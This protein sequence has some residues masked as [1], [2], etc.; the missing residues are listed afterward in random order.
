[1]RRAPLARALALALALALAGGVALAGCTGRPGVEPSAGPLGG[2]ALTV[3]DPGALRTI[4]V[5]VLMPPLEGEGSEYRDMAEGAAVAA[6]RFDQ[7]GVSVRLVAALDNGTPEGAATGLNSLLHNPEVAG[8]VVASSGPHLAPALAAVPASGTAVVMPYDRGGETIEGVWRTGPSEGAV[9]ARLADAL[10]RKGVAHPVVVTPA[11][12]PLDTLPAALPLTWSSAPAGAD[13]ALASCANPATPIDCLADR[14]SQALA[15]G[16]ADSVVAVGAAGDQAQLVTALRSAL[17]QAQVPVFL[18]PEA[19]TPTFGRGL[20]T[21]GA[22]NGDYITVGPNTDDPASQA[23]ADGQS[24]RLFF[25]ALRLAAGSPKAFNVFG[26]QPFASAAQTADIASHDAVVALVRAAEQAGTT[27]A[28]AVREV[29]GGLGLDSHRG[30]AGP[31]LDFRQPNALAA[32]SVVVLQATT[33]NPGQRPPAGAGQARP[34]F[35]FAV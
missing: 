3:Y 8:V 35:W 2:V 7:G 21:S 14:A 15:A 4:S 20:T 11:G 32:A 16:R 31:A 13:P 10:A 1:M 30:L 26:D 25:E 9:E 33:A 29:L 12:Q 28:A 17:G 27:D 24:A 22:V 5:G 6:F 23:G 18:S 19:L 34:V